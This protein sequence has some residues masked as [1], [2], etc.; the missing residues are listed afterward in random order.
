[1]GLVTAPRFCGSNP[2]HTWV[3]LHL[4]ISQ[5]LCGRP[6]ALQWTTLLFI[7]GMLC[8]RP[9]ALPMDDSFAHRRS[10]WTFGSRH[11]D[12]PY[13]R[14]WDLI[15]TIPSIAPMSNGRPKIL[16][17]FNAHLCGSDHLFIYLFFNLGHMS[18][19]HWLTCRIDCVFQRN[20][21]MSSSEWLASL[22]WPH[23]W[24]L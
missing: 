14:T 4:R 11:L 21:H 23:F 19:L 20:C 6:C 22:C 2:P 5:V 3:S 16:L 13:R 7:N 8:D 24:A 12:D 18:W 9:C 15:F 10:I 17:G 1:M